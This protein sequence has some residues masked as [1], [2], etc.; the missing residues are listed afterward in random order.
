MTHL[1][2]LTALTTLAALVLAIA[3]LGTGAAQGD[4]AGDR[5]RVEIRLPNHLALGMH[6]QDVFI[7]RDGEPGV[8]YRVTADD[9]DRDAPLYATARPVAHN[10][11]DPSDVGPF[12]QGPALGVTQGDWLDG[13][14]HAV[15]TCEGDT[16]HVSATFD[17][18]V[19]NG[20][21]TLWYFF[22]AMPPTAPFATYDL[23]VGDR[24]GSE[25]TFHA[26]AQGHASLEV[27]VRPCL[28]LSGRQ[29]L[30]GLAAAYHSDGQ[31]YGGLPGDFG[32]V[33]HLHVFNFLPA[34]SDALVSAR[35][36]D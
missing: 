27:E 3:A 22:M 10:P 4:D 5:Y 28:Q 9:V 24:A 30:A 7:A 8:V 33:A 1:R 12:E 17:G 29:L 36:A 25:N 14:G 34:E 2:T 15:V 21:Y 18:L 20:V 19:P 35:A 32:T 26:D 23:P 11:V 16:G 6:E 13:V 31:T